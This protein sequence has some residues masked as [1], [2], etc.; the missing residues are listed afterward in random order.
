MTTCEEAFVAHMRR[1]CPALSDPKEYP[2]EFI[3]STYYEA[4][5]DWVAAARWG[6]TNPGQVPSGL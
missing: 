4:L 3:C 1:V 5:V 6:Q 2:G